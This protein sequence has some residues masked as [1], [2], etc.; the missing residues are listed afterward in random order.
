MTKS[1]S[2]PDSWSL[3]AQLHSGYYYAFVTEVYGIFVFKGL[4]SHHVSSTSNLHEKK[5]IK[6]NNSHIFN[7]KKLTQSFR[8]FIWIQVSSLRFVCICFFP[9]PTKKQPSCI[10]SHWEIFYHSFVAP[11]HPL[12]VF[13]LKK[14]QMCCLHINLLEPAVCT[15]IREMTFSR[16]LLLKRYYQIIKSIVRAPRNVPFS[17]F[18]RFV[19]L[20]RV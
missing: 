8:L 11:L 5:V 6:Q 10:I 3:G 19:N 4:G 17:W 15:W 16:Q 12:L 13:C 9:S 1:A 20:P 7:L 18:H 14:Y 2:L